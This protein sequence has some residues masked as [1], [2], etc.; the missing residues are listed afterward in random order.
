MAKSKKLNVK[1][2][3]AHLFMSIIGN[4]VDLVYHDDYDNGAGLG[5]ALSSAMEEDDK[6]FDIVSAALLTA[7]ESK[8]SKANWERVKFSEKEKDI[9]KTAK[10]PVKTPTKSVNKK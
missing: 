4:Q 1:D 8:E 10:K 6:L 3:R 5:A 7:C 2:I 9:S